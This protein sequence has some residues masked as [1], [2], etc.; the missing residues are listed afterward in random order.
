[1]H[2]VLGGMTVGDIHFACARSD[3]DARKING[4]PLGRADFRTAE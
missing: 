2:P 4:Q 1:M 3:V